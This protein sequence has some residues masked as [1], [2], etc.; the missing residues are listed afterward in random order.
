MAAET[1]DCADK[2][3]F[4]FLYTRFN[5]LIGDNVLVNQN[6]FVEFLTNALASI[7]RRRHA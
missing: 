3:L 2:G 5:P 6:G 1:M 7:R 4:Q